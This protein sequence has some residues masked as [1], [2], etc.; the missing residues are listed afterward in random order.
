M[1]AGLTGNEFQDVLGARSS[2]RQIL[3]PS[4]ASRTGRGLLNPQPAFRCGFSFMAR[5]LRSV[6]LLVR[7]E[8]P[9]RRLHGRIRAPLLLDQVKLDAAG[10]LRRVE[11][12]L[13]GRDT[14]TEQHLVPFVGLRRPVLQ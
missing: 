8:T 1:D 7:G 12:L 6:N 10:L 5:A 11:N 14:F 13:P 3:S 9:L 4:W 2:R